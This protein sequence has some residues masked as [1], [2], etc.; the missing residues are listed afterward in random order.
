MI[1][2]WLYSGLAHSVARPDRPNQ[3]SGS[4]RDDGQNQPREPPGIQGRAAE[5]TATRFGMIAHSHAVPL[6]LALDPT[7]SIQE[8]RPKN[9]P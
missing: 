8:L 1:G 7:R 4:A 9:D 5:K 2:P 6:T 3:N